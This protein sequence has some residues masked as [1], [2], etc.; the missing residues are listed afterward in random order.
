MG[1][2]DPQTNEVNSAKAM[3][4]DGSIV[5]STVTI[6]SVR[7]IVTRYL[8]EQMQRLFAEADD[9]LF[10][11]S[12]QAG[13]TSLESEYFLAMRLI[14][15]ESNNLKARYEAAVL[16]RYDDFWQPRPKLL[17]GKGGNASGKVFGFDESDFSLVGE[18]AFEEDLAVS[19]M[20]DKGK[21]LFSK[22]LFAL[23]KRIAHMAG[24]EELDKDENPLGPE[25]F[26]RSFSDALSPLPLDFR[27]K[28]L[29]YKLYDRVVV[30]NLDVFLGEVETC[31]IDEGILPNI[32]RTSKIRRAPSREDGKAPSNQTALVGR[33]GEGLE[34][35]QQA[36][37]EVFESMQSLLDDWRT[38][39]GM[40]ALC[41]TSGGPSV[42]M[43]DVLSILSLLQHPA[44]A[45]AALTVDDLK[46]HVQQQLGGDERSL[47]RREEDVIDM[48][49]MIFDF[50]LEDPN[51]PD[52]VKA[53]I[54]RLQ[55]P[56]VKVAILERSFFGQKN[57]PVRLLLN[58][59][60]QAGIGLDMEEGGRDAPV[61]KYIES[62]VNRILDEFGQDVK[63]FSELLDEF[64]AFMEKE[65][66]RSRVAEERTVQATHSKERVQLCKR[67]VAYEIA[68][69]LRDKQVPAPVRSFLF[70]TWKDVMVLANLRRD[71][72]PADWDQSLQIMDKLIWSVTVPINPTSRKELSEQL[73]LLVASLRTGLD[74]L[75]LDPQTVADSL[76]DLLGCHTIHLSGGAKLAVAGQSAADQQKVRIRDPE[77]AKAISEI[78]CNLPDVESLNLADLMET[79]RPATVVETVPDEFMA[80][81]LSLAV[82]QWVEFNDDGK[83]SRA[84]LSWKSQT[85]STHVF[86]NRKGTKVAEISLALL[87]S[88]FASGSAKTIDAAA[89]PL[90]DRAFRA[91]MSTLKGP[92]DEA[93]ASS[94]G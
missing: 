92:M 21:N 49:S 73:P 28:L 20:V 11:L 4:M 46:T 9:Q 58:A 38:R 60:A 44:G 93:V 84:K 89:V 59:L 64:T 18:E 82:G 43:A 66:Q 29:I 31:L 5:A 26:C 40:P 85:T 2:Q 79:D 22:E 86:V 65:T 16:K 36:Y 47:A 51:L 74:T 23:D 53:L 10:N 94:S 3:P 25:A 12:G 27:I 50:I 61:F 37:L 1:P 70:N 68:Q 8:A 56:V 14:R 41:A 88:R 76:K 90:M 33:F 81:A 19:G 13:N 63:L 54:T 91:L 87:A 57:H 78:Q 39:V 67:K 72:A 77:L 15:R 80:K 35:S 7:S 32:T 55:I 24:R 83:R 34:E 69:R 52:A 6:S 45:N 48:V 71:R 42:P 17:G 62:I 30:G 75:S